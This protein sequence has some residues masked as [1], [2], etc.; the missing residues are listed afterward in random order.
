MTLC[1]LRH[2]LPQALLGAFYGISQPTV[3]RLI[4][5]LRELVRQAAIEGMPGLADTAPEERVLLDGTLLPTGQRSGQQGPALYSG[6]RH[7]AGMNV[8]V[9]GDRC[10]RLVE[11]S[12]PTPGSMHDA[13]SFVVCG[14]DR[15][16]AD[17][18][19]LADLGFLGCGVSTPLRKPKG[20][21]L[22][23]LERANNRAHASAR[24]PVERTI[25]LFKQ[26]RVVGSGYRGPLVRFPKVIRTVVA[27]EKFL[28]FRGYAA[29]LSPV[30][31]ACGNRSRV[32]WS[33]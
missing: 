31:R 13:R 21:R 15:T 33:G 14:P 20:G 7:R 17:H 28:V 8:Q 4:A 24:A 6:R 1:W 11:V 16:L 26:W 18:H 19:V 5:S 3:S 2:N 27:L 25:A 30:S 32:C 22:C 29:G 9:I 10:G 12:D 23:E